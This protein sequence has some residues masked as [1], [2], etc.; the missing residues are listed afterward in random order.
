MQNPFPAH[1]AA[2]QSDTHFLIVNEER[3]IRDFKRI[4][5]LIIRANSADT[6]GEKVLILSAEYGRGKTHYQF[7]LQNWILGN[8]CKVIGLDYELYKQKNI[9]PVYLKFTSSLVS[10]KESLYYHFIRTLFGDTFDKKNFS[11]RGLANYEHFTDKQREDFITIVKKRYNEITGKKIDEQFQMDDGQFLQLLD[12]LFKTAIEISNATS[13]VIFFDELESLVLNEDTAIRDF[14]GDFLR[15]LIDEIPENK[16]IYM[17]FAASAPA[18][19]AIKRGNLARAFM[20]RLDQ[21]IIRLHLFTMIEI[22]S[23]IAYT[24][25]NDFSGKKI[26]P[27]TDDAIEALYNLYRGHPRRTLQICHKVY[28][29]FLNENLKE[30]NYL[31]IITSGQDSGS[32]TLNNDEFTKMIRSL[33]SCR[34]IITS[35]VKDN[36]GKSNIKISD[37]KLTESSDE[38]LE[39]KLDALEKEGFIEIGDNEDLIVK[40]IFY[41]KLLDRDT[42]KI[43]GE[44]ERSESK[45][46]PIY[47]FEKAC[48]SISDLI[49]KP[50]Y[51]DKK[52]NQDKIIEEMKNYYR[53]YCERFFEDSGINSI[54]SG[55][56]FIK[57]S[58]EHY[59]DVSQ[60]IYFTLYFSIGNDEPDHI[61]ERILQFMTESK[62]PHLIVILS[63][64]PPKKLDISNKHPQEFIWGKSHWIKL[65]DF[66][67]DDSAETITTI[68]DYLRQPK[69]DDVLIQRKIDTGFI[70][71]KYKEDSI[72]VNSFSALISG[73]NLYSSTTTEMADELRNLIN[74]KIFSIE[75]KLGGLIKEKILEL[76][77]QKTS[78]IMPKISKNTIEALKVSSQV[79]KFRELISTSIIF[80]QNDLEKLGIKGTQINQL[81]SYGI[82]DKNVRSISFNSFNDAI[83]KNVP[84]ALTYYLLKDGEKSTTEIRKA[85][86]DFP[87]TIKIY[88][89]LALQMYVSIGWINL[90]DKK[91]SLSSN[92]L[93]SKTDILKTEFQILKNF[94]STLRKY[95]CSNYERIKEDLTNL[96]K[97]EENSDRSFQNGEITNFQH[98]SILESIIKRVKSKNNVVNNEILALKTNVDEKYHELEEKQKISLDLLK[99]NNQILSRLTFTDK[100]SVLAKLKSQEE[101]DY[102][103]SLNLN[104]ILY[105]K[106]KTIDI[107]QKYQSLIALRD[108]E[109][110]CQFLNEVK[111]TLENLEQ[112][113]KEVNFSIKQSVEILNEQFRKN[114]DMMLVLSNMGRNISK[115]KEFSDN[116]HDKIKEIDNIDQILL[117][118]VLTGNEII[119]VAKDY[120]KVFN[121]KANDQLE[122]FNIKIQNLSDRMKSDCDILSNF[123]SKNKLINPLKEITEC[124][125]FIERNILNIEK[126][127]KSAEDKL[128]LRQISESSLK[129]L[130]NKISEKL[131][132]SETLLEKRLD[133]LFRNWHELIT[134]ILE[135]EGDIGIF[136]SFL[137]HN[138]TISGQEIKEIKTKVKEQKNLGEI[139]LN[140]LELGLIKIIKGEE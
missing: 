58:L 114:Q 35:I 16:P 60:T 81:I 76:F 19:D 48:K 23:L 93:D 12:M 113:D 111:E 28:N 46:K 5:S 9:F 123:N 135:E 115:V 49:E 129:D 136:L 6:S 64:K 107:N 92:S 44:S 84:S 3:K 72:R 51:L 117:N 131:I 54:S 109:T 99:R 38:A 80:N 43:F 45:N 70:D 39:Q 73:L 127:I 67:K 42:S 25:N 57:F 17:F 82:L 47:E 100:A 102:I 75:Q 1:G 31:D 125:E 66:I 140:L 11:N 97:E 134:D 77:I 130:F 37:L 95:N 30:I 119:Q 98:T 4:E 139:I 34:E 83:I 126:E 24:L 33:P 78:L 105:I 85:L 120:I 52:E 94:I 10:K 56:D 71:I 138:E 63:L 55:T 68:N 112:V 104:K 69:I 40:P 41:S 15:N 2:D 79:E 116:F 90:K 121:A 88:Y 65:I 59:K 74:D 27:F 128:K 86:S 91:Y 18:I 118:L 53:N 103:N 7:F 87:N 110:F 108:N 36:F 89:D 61:K 21:A 29:R 32:F 50:G 13:I 133:A 62:Q 96:E 14:F 132:S 101:Q 122:T 106:T 137:S 124:K 8:K 20:D 22:R 26:K